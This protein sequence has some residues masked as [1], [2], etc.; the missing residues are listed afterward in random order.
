MNLNPA[1]FSRLLARAKTARFSRRHT[2]AAPSYLA[3][4]LKE[5]ES[6]QAIFEEEYRVYV[7]NISSPVAA[8]SLELAVF[9]YFVCVKTQPKVVLDLGSGF[10]SYVLRRY[11]Q[12]EAAEVYSVDDD[13]LWLDRTQD[14][15][16][17]HQLSTSNLFLWDDLLRSDIKITADLI[18]HDLGNSG[19]RVEAFEHLTRFAAPNAT[20]ILDDVHKRNIREAATR[21][22][23]EHDFRYVDLASYTR[24]AYGRFQWLVKTD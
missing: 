11:Q 2:A 6:I 14:F 19:K 9:L 23:R 17:S 13:K 12:A 7:E 3:D 18:L 16:S 10:S 1:S 20:L 8:V 22:I 4:W 15:L 24:D 21:W 5:R